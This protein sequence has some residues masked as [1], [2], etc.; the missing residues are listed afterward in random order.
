[1][2]P[3]GLSI[4]PAR[5][6]ELILGAIGTIAAMVGA[7]AAIQATLRSRSIPAMA[8][9]GTFPTRAPG[10]PMT[11]VAQG[12]MSEPLI[13]RF[14]LTDT[15]VTLL[16]IEVANQLDL[17]VRTAQCVEAA[18]GVF[19]A[20]LEARTVQR[21]YNGNPYWDGE[22]KRLPIQVFLRTSGQAEC[23]TIWVTMSPRTISN[24]GFLEMS[25]PIWFLEGPC[26]RATP[27]LVHMPS[28]TGTDGL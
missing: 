19:I 15:A 10:T 2:A 1:M 7:I 22:T 11:I 24:P 18:P 27:K 26:P 4:D 21:W 6:G 20:E 17:G 9:Q 16:R 8:D 13:L 28:R 5:V 14:T 12:R 3:I 25:D 23:R